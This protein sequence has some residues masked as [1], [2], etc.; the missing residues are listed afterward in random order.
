[1]DDILYGI[2]NEKYDEKCLKHGLHEIV[3][4]GAVYS[5]RWI[6]HSAVFFASVN[7]LI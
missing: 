1:M 4:I 2:V 6:Y 5:K 7:K 3:F